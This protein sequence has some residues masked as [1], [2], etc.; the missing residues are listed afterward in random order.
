MCCYTM[1]CRIHTPLNHHIQTI[2]HTFG[3]S[4]LQSVPCTT[5]STLK[6][7]KHRLLLSKS[8]PTKPNKMPSATPIRAMLRTLTRNMVEPHPFARNPLSVK[9]HTWRAGDLSKKMVR[10]SAVFFPFY[11]VILGWPIA[12]YTAFNGRL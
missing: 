11:A 7:T 9:P 12:A 2:D 1:H 10:T 8:D 4:T 3:T 6:P 5:K